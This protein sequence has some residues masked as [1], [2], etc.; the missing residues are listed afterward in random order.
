MPATIFLPS[1]PNPVKAARIRDLGATLVETGSDLTAAIDAARAF[2]AAGSDTFFLHD[3][4]DG[5][6]PAGTAQIGREIVEQL[7]STDAIYVPMG[8]TALI[9]GVAA[10]VKALQPSIRIVGVAAG[11]RRRITCRGRK[12][13][14]LRPSRR[15]RSPMAL[16]CDGRCARTWR[17]SG[18]WWTRSCW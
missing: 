16:P 17:T 7:P 10:A 8:D 2:A 13:R 18:D 14:R 4:E 12:A 11:T 5:E 3:A 9:R 15:T 1:N 6:I